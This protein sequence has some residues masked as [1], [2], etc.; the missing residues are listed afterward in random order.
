MKEKE[1]DEKGKIRGRTFVRG[2]HGCIT[3]G[4]CHKLGMFIKDASV[5]I[6]HVE[7]GINQFSVL[8]VN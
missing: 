7:G 3:A 5:I 1:G 6:F 8:C 4:V 2:T